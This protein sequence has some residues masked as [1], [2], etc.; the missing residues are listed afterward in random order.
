VVEVG[1][2]VVDAMRV[3]V[4]KEMGEIKTEEAFV[5]FQLR[6]LVPAGAKAEGEAEKEE[7]V[8]GEV[9]DLKVAI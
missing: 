9:F 5:M 2:T 7:M 1:F 6:V 8:G 4:L 3:V